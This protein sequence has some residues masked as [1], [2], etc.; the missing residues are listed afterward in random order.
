[1]PGRV[2]PGGGPSDGGSVVVCFLQD[3]FAGR[4]C[5]VN[6]C[7]MRIPRGRTGLASRSELVAGRNRVRL[8]LGGACGQRPTADR[9]QGL[10][11]GS[12]SNLWVVPRRGCR[13]TSKSDTLNDAHRDVPS[14]TH[15]S[16][17]RLQTT[18]G[19]R[20]L[21][22]MDTLTLGLG[23]PTLGKWGKDGQ[24]SSDQGDVVAPS[25]EGSG[26]ASPAERYRPS[27]VAG[28]TTIRRPFVPRVPA[29]RSGP[30]PYD[31]KARCLL[32][33]G[34]YLLPPLWPGRGGGLYS[35]RGADPAGTTAAAVGTGE[36]AHRGEA[37]HNRNIG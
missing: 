4:F 23:L 28:R 29:R 1:M 3:L 6:S 10:G 5:S 22:E 37:G 33:Y 35:R 14:G 24:T 31:G 26:A 9:R 27:T 21:K 34:F 13:G 25:G 12:F 2:W 32:R 18:S 30:D 8:G 36:E 20:A 7:S 17:G 16:G 11:E 19:P 15:Q